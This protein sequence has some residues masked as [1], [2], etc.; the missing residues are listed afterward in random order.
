MSA[1]ADQFDELNA[2]A[3]DFRNELFGRDQAGTQ[4]KFTADGLADPLPCYFTTRDGQ[5]LNEMMMKEIHDGYVR[6]RKSTGF[7]PRKGQVIKLLNVRQGGGDMTFEIEAFNN[8]AINPEFVL[9]V[10]A[11]F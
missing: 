1:F 11:Q 3:A 10:K 6:I 8:T 9:P 5:E 4:Q 7:V 2:G